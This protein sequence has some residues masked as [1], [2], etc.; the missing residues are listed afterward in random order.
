[1][2]DHGQWMVNKDYLM[3]HVLA[4]LVEQMPQQSFI[5][6]DMQVH[7]ILEPMEDERWLGALP[8]TLKVFKKECARTKAQADSGGGGAGQ[9]V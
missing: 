4:W 5:P 9:E 2:Y 3:D 8:E 1:M 6:D 7:E